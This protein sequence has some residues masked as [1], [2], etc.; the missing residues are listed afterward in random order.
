[1]LL[2]KLHMLK[3]LKD[4]LTAKSVNLILP[5]GIFDFILF[6]NVRKGTYVREYGKQNL[7]YVIP[8][9]GVYDD[10]LRGLCERL[11]GSEEEFH[12]NMKLIRVLGALTVQEKYTVICSLKIANGLYHKKITFIRNTFFEK[13]SKQKE[14]II[15]FCEDITEI[16]FNREVRRENNGSRSG[17]QKENAEILQKRIV[18]LVHEIRTS[19]TSIYGSLTLLREEWHPESGYLD[20]AVLSAEYLLNLVNSILD[21]S[22]LE[23]HGV[24]KIEAVMLEELARYPQG[25][26]AQEAERRNIRLQFLFGEPV[27]QYLYV[28]RTVV[29]QIIIN[30]ISNALKY[31]EG[32]GQVVCHMREL[33]QEEKRVRLLL[34]VSDTGIGMEEEFLVDVWKSYKREGRKRGAEGSGLGLALTKRLVEM[35]HGTIRIETKKNTGTTVTVVLEVDGDDVLYESSGASGEAVGEEPVSI[36]RALVAEDEDA[37][38]EVLCGYLE[39]MGIAADKTYDGDEVLEIFRQSEEFYYDVILMDVHMPGISGYEAVGKIRSMGRNDSGLPIIAVTADIL[40]KQIVEEMSV[41][42]NGYLVKPYRIED[43]R[44]VLLQISGSWKGND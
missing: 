43:I 10:F 8:E 33:Y 35:L 32:G 3:F 37:N 22:A 29:Q 26:F 1:M 14:N 31:T 4:R 44:S 17:Q 23:G 21:I 36:K 6:V 13:S 19:L 2:E 41:K 39:K 11:C 15:V 5:E 38:M 9:E 25:I 16:F 30:M 24:G 12:E 40:D 34:E 28:N 20:N 18:Y 27:Y 7:P 42:V